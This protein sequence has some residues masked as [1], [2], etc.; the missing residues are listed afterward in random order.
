MPVDF[1]EKELGR[2]QTEFN[3]TFGVMPLCNPKIRIRVM[4]AIV[5][6]CLLQR[7]IMKEKGKEDISNFV[8]TKDKLNKIFSMLSQ[9]SKKRK[10]GQKSKNKQPEITGSGNGSS[11]NVCLP[12]MQ[13]CL[14]NQTFKTG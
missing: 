4:F 3:Q 11:T 5:Q 1:F 7:K 2:V 10:H 13:I 14:S 8:K 9:E 6:M 12:E